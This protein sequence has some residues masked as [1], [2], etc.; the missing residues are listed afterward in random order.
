M[1][2]T[3]A[4]ARAPL[5]GRA[6]CPRPLLPSSPQTN[7]MALAAGGHSS[8]DFLKFGTP[9]QLVLVRPAA[10]QSNGPGGCGGVGV[11]GGVL[12]RAGGGQGAGLRVRVR[13]RAGKSRGGLEDVWRARD[14]MPRCRW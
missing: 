5:L 6:S 13:T 4:S 11:G 2:N 8:R 3:R 9:M 1:V 14:A 12:G 7:L 10:W